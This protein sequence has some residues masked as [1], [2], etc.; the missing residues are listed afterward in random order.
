MIQATIKPYQTIPRCLQFCGLSE[1]GDVHCEIR[2]DFAL[3]QLLKCLAYLRQACLP[4]L[5]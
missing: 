2:D 5:W 3:L 4:S 1:N